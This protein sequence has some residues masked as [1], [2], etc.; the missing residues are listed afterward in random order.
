MVET[1]NL[2][3][4]LLACTSIAKLKSTGK[5]SSE[6]MSFSAFAFI[7]EQAGSGQTSV[8]RARLSGKGP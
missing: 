1:V 6:F 3:G 5:R 2:A 8:R 7:P 4:M